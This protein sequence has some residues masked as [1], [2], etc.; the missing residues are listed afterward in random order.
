[1][2]KKPLE[3]LEVMAALEDTVLRKGQPELIRCIRDTKTLLPLLSQQQFSR[4]VNNVVA[5]TVATII[6]IVCA[7]SSFTTPVIMVC[8]PQSIK[9]D[10]QTLQ[11]VLDVIGELDVL[12][13][14]KVSVME[15]ARNYVCLKRL[16]NAETNGHQFSSDVHSKLLLESCSRQIKDL[17]GVQSCSKSC[18]FHNQC[19]Y[20][21]FKREMASGEKKIQAYTEQMFLSHLRGNSLPQKRMVVY[22]SDIELDANSSCVLKR[23]DLKKLLTQCEMLC[24]PAKRQKRA[25]FQETAA[26]RELEKELFFNPRITMAQANLILKD[27][28]DRFVKIEKLCAAALSQKG[29]ERELW[30][31]RLNGKGGAKATQSRSSGNR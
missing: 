31:N 1:M 11:E 17:L 30:K 23:Y 3:V 6:R 14:P 25:V 29:T 24:S 13:I 9:A 5:G 19:R 20:Q 4:P 2:L 27:I 15:P 8:K 7:D 26:I 28:H 12:P 21:E 10:T 16:R 22:P 18:W